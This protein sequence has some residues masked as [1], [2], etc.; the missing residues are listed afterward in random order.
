MALSRHDDDVLIQYG[1]SVSDAPRSVD[2]VFV[3][4]VFAAYVK[5]EL[6]VCV[7]TELF[8]EVLVNVITFGYT[9]W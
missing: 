8:V 5:A 7:H 2:S 3:D 4:L 9:V 6:C 1:I